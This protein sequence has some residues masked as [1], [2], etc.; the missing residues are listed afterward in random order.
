MLTTAVR[1]NGNNTTTAG[2]RLPPDGHEF[3]SSFT[4]EPTGLDISN[5]SIRGGWKD[6]F[7][8]HKSVSV[9]DSG[10][11]CSTPSSDES[12]SPTHKSPSPSF[13][14]SPTHPESALL[15]NQYQSPINGDRHVE[16]VHFQ[17]KILFRIVY[18]N[19]Y[20]YICIYNFCHMAAS[21]I[22]MQSYL[23]CMC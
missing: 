7:R 18:L 8:G 22:I 6:A 15:A 10:V 11:F 23:H 12:P 19:L 14:A 21:Y 9:D 17:F 4:E 3:P 1:F 13:S 5:M 20:I 16:T 2:S